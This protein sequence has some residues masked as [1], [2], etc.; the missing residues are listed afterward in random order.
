MRGRYEERISIYSEDLSVPTHTNEFRFCTSQL[1]NQ[2]WNWTCKNKLFHS[3]LTGNVRLLCPSLS[4]L[5]FHYKIHTSRTKASL[6]GKLSVQHNQLFMNWYGK[7]IGSLLHRE[8]ISVFIISNRPYFVPYT[9]LYNMFNSRNL[10]PS[11]TTRDAFM[12]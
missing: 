4:K 7:P 6:N 11:H 1:C 9:I 12:N 10:T 5:E 3:F 8:S 2:W